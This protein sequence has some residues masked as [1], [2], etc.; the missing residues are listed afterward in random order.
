MTIVCKSLL[1]RAR[2]QRKQERYC[3]AAHPANLTIG[4]KSVFHELD[5]ERCR[6]K[7][8]TQQRQPFVAW[9]RLQTS[10]FGRRRKVTTDTLPVQKQASYY[11]SPATRKAFRPPTRF[12]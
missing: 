7:G 5:S 11:R 9:N 12:F 4:F 1:R 3:Q 6:R 8:V 10:I 2:P